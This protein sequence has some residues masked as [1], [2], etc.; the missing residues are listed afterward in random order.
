MLTEIAAGVE[1]FTV[2]A[3][4]VFEVVVIAECVAA[5]V[6]TDHGAAVAD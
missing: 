1:L 2:I 5:M 3:F 6:E 4:D